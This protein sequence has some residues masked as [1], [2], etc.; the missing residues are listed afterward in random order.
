MDRAIGVKAPLQID[1]T[2]FRDTSTQIQA[3]YCGGLLAAFKNAVVIPRGAI[4]PK[5]VQIL[6]PRLP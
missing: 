3:V 2:R 6:A 5:I 1:L 4:L